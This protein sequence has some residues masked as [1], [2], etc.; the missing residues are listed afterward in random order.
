MFY[1]F[2]GESQINCPLGNFGCVF[3][4]KQIPQRLQLLP[5]QMMKLEEVL[6]LESKRNPQLSRPPLPPR[7]SELKPKS[8]TLPTWVPLPCLS[9]CTF[10]RDTLM[11][12]P[13]LGLLQ[14]LLWREPTGGR[15]D[16]GGKPREWEHHPPPVCPAQELRPDPQT[17]DLQVWFLY[18]K[19]LANTN[20][21]LKK[22]YKIRNMYFSL[23]Q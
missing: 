13:S 12:F 20:R 7:P 3:L 22:V 17:K 23:G 14:V 15:E 10:T 2:S 1:L 11:F 8:T 21:T 4:Q 5:G 9:V 18:R 19:P 6:E 16:A